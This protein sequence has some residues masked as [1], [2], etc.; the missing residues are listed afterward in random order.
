MRKIAFIVFLAVALISC[1]GKKEVKQVSQESRITAEAFAVAEALRDAF[2]RKDV[3]TLQKNSTEEGFKDITANQKVYDTVELAFTPRWVEIE[4]G[5][6]HVNIAW[7][8]AWTLSG[9]TSDARGMTVFRMEG[10]PAKLSKIVRS[11]PFIFPEQ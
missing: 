11:N 7:K 10:K 9:R 8:S 2:I 5:K 3:A 6:L 1:S 4:D